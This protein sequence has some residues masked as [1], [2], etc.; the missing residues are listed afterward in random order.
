LKI[1]NG[2]GPALRDQGRS[3]LTPKTSAKRPSVIF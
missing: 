1:F 2:G 3:Q